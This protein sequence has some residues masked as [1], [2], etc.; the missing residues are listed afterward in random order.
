M[1]QANY[2]IRYRIDGSAA[3]MRLRGRDL[4]GDIDE[5]VDRYCGR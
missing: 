1:V 2:G 3:T 4:Q 5:A